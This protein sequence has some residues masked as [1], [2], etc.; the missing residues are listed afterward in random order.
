MNKLACLLC[1]LNA[2]VVFAQR[3]SWDGIWFTA[4]PEYEVMQ[5]P[6]V[7]VIRKMITNIPAVWDHWFCTQVTALIRLHIK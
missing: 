6:A 4:S 5:F 7:P 2:G 1:M 3:E